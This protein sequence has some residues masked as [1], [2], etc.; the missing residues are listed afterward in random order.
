MNAGDTGRSLALKFISYERQ[1]YK[2]SRELFL[3]LPDKQSQLIKRLP[4]M[5][6]I[7]NILWLATLYHHHWYALCAS[8]LQAGDI[9]I[10]TFWQKDSM[11]LIPLI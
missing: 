11:K 10:V 9:G 8:T 6:F 7:L 5:N 3:S 1:K 4:D 2:K